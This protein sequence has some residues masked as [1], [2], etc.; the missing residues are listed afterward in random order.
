M[1]TYDS[2]DLTDPIRGL[3]DKL[4]ALS[5]HLDTRFRVSGMDRIF[6]HKTRLMRN[7][8]VLHVAVTQEIGEAPLRSSNSLVARIPGTHRGVVFGIWSETGYEEAEG[9]LRAMRTGAPPTSEETDNYDPAITREFDHGSLIGRPA[10]TGRPRLRTGI[11]DDAGPD[12]AAPDGRVHPAPELESPLEEA[13][14]N[15]DFRGRW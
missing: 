8:P 9:L 3:A 12:V 14:E 2:K 5:R 1:R 13:Y 15:T 11:T 4:T 10:R 7:S 6:F